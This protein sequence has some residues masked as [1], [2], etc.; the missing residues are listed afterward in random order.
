MTS[1]KSK[2]PARRRTRILAAMALVLALAALAY[3][4]GPWTLARLRSFRLKMNVIVIVV[5]TLRADKLGCQGGWQELTPNIDAFAK[6]AVVFENAFSHAPWTLPSMA[7][8]YTS[9]LP[10]QHGAGGKLGKFKVLE[11]GASTLAEVFRRNGA[12]TGAVTNVLFLGQRFGMTQGFDDVDEALGRDNRTGRRAGGTTEA[13]IQWIEENTPGRFFLL[14]H[15]FDPHLTYDPPGKWRMRFAKDVPG[16]ESFGTAKEMAALRKGERELDEAQIPHLERLYNAEIAYTDFQVGRLLDE[17]EKMGLSD[18]TL[19]ILTSD[20]GEEFL[21]HGGFEHGHSLF[22]EL[23]HVP[24]IVR[25]PGGGGSRVAS[26]V[27][28]IDVAPTICDL[29]GIDPPSSF[30]GRSLLPLVESGGK[31]RP[32]LAQGNMWGPERTAWRDGRFKI[33]LDSESGGVLLFDVVSDPGEQKDVAGEM[34]GLRTKML[35]EAN[36]MIQSFAAGGES[37]AEL[38]EEEI[39]MLRSLGYIE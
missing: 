37:E 35:T 4:F 23:L 15:Y 10:V 27:R 13:A 33:I 34:E 1:N 18:D 19:V 16:G 22:N 6:E 14:V 7:S 3:H 8:L 20:H 31:D 24:L 29:V 9:Q 17:L 28:L 21:D 25:I 36:A 39:E 26:V 30:W 2:R 32:M 5:D 11:P 12:S 38:S